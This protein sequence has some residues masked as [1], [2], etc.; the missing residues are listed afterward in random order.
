[1]HTHYNDGSKTIEQFDTLDKLV[2]AVEAKA[3]DP[4]VKKII[5]VFPKRKIPSNKRRAA[6][7]VGR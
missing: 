5:I 4:N 2:Y 3:H 7:R 1:M 6:G